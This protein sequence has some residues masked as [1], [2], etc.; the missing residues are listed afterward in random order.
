MPISSNCTGKINS[1]IFK[2]FSVSLLLIQKKEERKKK[3]IEKFLK[4]MR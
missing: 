3:R 1:D 2:D 4:D